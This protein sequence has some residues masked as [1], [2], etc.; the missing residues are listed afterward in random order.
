M[1]PPDLNIIVERY[2]F[3]LSAL[4]M[5]K[6]FI[7]SLVLVSYPERVIQGVNCG[8]MAGDKRRAAACQPANNVNFVHHQ[9]CFTH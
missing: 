2:D 4:E 7:W 1:F 8:S 6:K 5:Q 9:Q 3:T